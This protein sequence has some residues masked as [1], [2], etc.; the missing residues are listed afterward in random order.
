MA[1]IDPRGAPDYSHYDYAA[2][3][4]RMYEQGKREGAADKANGKEPNAYLYLVASSDYSYA[5]G[6]AR[7]TVSPSMLMDA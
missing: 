7:G 6:Y 1:K 3:G 2:E 4:I 5:K